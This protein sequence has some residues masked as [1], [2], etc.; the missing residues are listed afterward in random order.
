MKAAKL[1]EVFVGRP[2]PLGRGNVSSGFVKHSVSG[3]LGV[4]SLGLPGDEQADLRVHGGP[5]MAVYVY[6]SEHYG[7]W[8]AEFP[9]HSVLWRRGGLGENFS[10][11]GWDESEICIGDTVRLGGALFQ[12]TRPRKPCFKLALRFDDLRLPRRLVETG[13]CGWYFRVLEEGTIAPG[14]AAQVID[15]R[16]PAWTIK[17]VNDV[18][19]GPSPNLDEL[20]ELAAIPELA[21]NWRA[22]VNAGIAAAKATERSRTFRKFAVRSVKNESRHIRSFVLEPSDGCGIPQAL[23]GQ[24]VIVRGDLDGSASHISRAYSLSSI[25]NGQIQISVKREAGALSEWLHD[26]VRVGDDLTL[27]GPRGAFV[28]DTSSSAP[29]VLISAGVGITPMMAMLQAATTNNG[30]RKVPDSIT[31]IHSARNSAEQAFAAQLDEIVCRHPSVRRHIR[32]SQPSLED[33]LGRTHDS[34]GRIDRPLLESLIAGLDGC[35]VYVCGPPA[36]MSDVV[37][38]IAD[39]GLRHASVFTERFRPLASPDCHVGVPPLA[40]ALVSFSVSGLQAEWKRGMSLLDLAEE[41]GISVNNQCRSG[42]CGTCAARLVKGSI[43]YTT[44]PLAE[45]AEGEV[46][47]CCVYPKDRRISLA[48]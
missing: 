11:E 39:L 37:R 46:L 28:L 29:L 48:I 19:I 5:D 14:D 15:R 2:A 27:L 44:R 38:W 30:S 20:A 31:F 7:A 10:M 25:G 18:S 12:V 36:L 26:R 40:E 22:Q 45:I 23:P 13:R 3:A 16:N 35:N 41:N 6:P 47:L 8:R 21:T 1:K 17:R 33:E 4:T 43:G 9:E 24:H 34:V 32:Y 42:I